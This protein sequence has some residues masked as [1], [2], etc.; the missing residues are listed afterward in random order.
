MKTDTKTQLYILHLEDAAVPSFISASKPYIGAENDLQLI[1]HRFEE[2][3]SYTKTAEGIREYFSGNHAVM[4]SVAYHDYP[5]LE[6]VRMLDYSY[7]IQ[8]AFQW[9]HMNAWGFPYHM[10]CSKAVYNQIVFMYNKKY[11]RCVRA[12]LT[13]LY[14]LGVNGEKRFLDS[15]FW[16]NRC[17]LLVQPA[18]QGG[19]DVR[20]VLYVVENACDSKIE[21][22]NQ[23]HSVEHI[24]LSGICEDIFADG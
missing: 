6:P 9:D 4:H 8:D 20:N 11:Y 2:E 19:F 1:A 24:D 13:D 14:Y 3:N 18:P 21:A 15:E 5:V 17:N 10:G 16:G 7:L 12:V 23:L 22:S